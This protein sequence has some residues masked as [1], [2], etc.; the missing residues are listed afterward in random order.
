[1][2][3]AIAVR[4]RQA[5]R[6]DAGAAASARPVSS[7]ALVSLT[8]ECFERL[9]HLIRG[10]RVMLDSDLARLYGV[11]TSG[12]NRALKR[13]LAR[14]PEDFAFQLSLRETGS[15]RYQIGISN[16]RGG[17]R[18]RPYAFTE[19]GVAMLSSILRS[20]RAV[21]VNIGIMRAFVQLRELLASNVRLARK[22]D[23]L[24]Q[25]YDDR[26]HVVFQAIRR[27]MDAELPARRRRS[28]GFRPPAAM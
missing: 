18:Y 22:L 19:Q 13:N 7:K 9:I 15:L 20:E 27:L 4:R 17:R 24:E 12:L 8:P 11:T 14:F 16:G 6:S 28:I 26:F 1:M 2:Q 5:R 3:A 23:E 21:R 25:K 10:Q